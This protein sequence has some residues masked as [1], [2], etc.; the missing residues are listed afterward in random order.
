MSRNLYNKIK[1]EYS[2]RQKDSFDLQQ[3]RKQEVY[4]KE[5]RIE[6]IDRRIQ[7]VGLKYS[8]LLL[9]GSVSPEAA[10]EKIKTEIDAL[11]KEKEELLRQNGYP[12]DYLEPVY[13]CP[14]CRDTG[15][16]DDLS[17]KPVTCSCYRQLRINFI[18]AQ[19]NIKLSGNENFSCF[20]EN[21]YSDKPDPERYGITNS[22]RQQ[23]IGIKNNCLKFIQQFHQKETKNMLFTGTAGVGKTFMAVCVAVELMNKGYT[24]LYQSAPVLFN[25]IYEYRFRNSREEE[26]VSDFYDNILNSNLLI[27]DDLGTEPPSAAKY[28]EL[29]TILDARLANDL[30]HPCK[31]IIST[32]IDLRMLYDYYDERIISRIIGNFDIYRFIG[33][34]IRKIKLGL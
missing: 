25:N 33:E 14:K 31:T 8:K 1:N 32:N 26:Y 11:K 30:A 9:H 19:S 27:I 6:E 22:P 12:S 7:Q 21:Y 34:D 4:L 28:A 17:G 3:Q 24:V 10:S 20:N 23:I 2:K 29:L 13:V 5:P 18:Y 16:I 15:I